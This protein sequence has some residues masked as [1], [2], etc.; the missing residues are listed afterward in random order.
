MAEELLQPPREGEPG[1]QE[2]NAGEPT[3]PMPSPEREGI[4]LNSLPKLLLPVS[5]RTWTPRRWQLQQHDAMK[6]KM[7]QREAL[8]NCSFYLVAPF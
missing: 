2:A 5:P 7:W 1:T 8:L 6:M 3:E 4:R